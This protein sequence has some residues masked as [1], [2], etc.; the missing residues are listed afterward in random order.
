MKIKFISEREE[1]SGYPDTSNNLTMETI[2]DPNLESLIGSFEDFL[3]GCGYFLPDGASLG[4]EY[5]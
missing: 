1:C 2:S 4:Y 5:D 3:K